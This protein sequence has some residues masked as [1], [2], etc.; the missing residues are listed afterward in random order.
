MRP[1]QRTS[2]GSSIP[3]RP[4]QLEPFPG[5][6]VEDL[7]APAYTRGLTSLPEVQRRQAMHAADRMD[8]DNRTFNQQFW[9][10]M[11]SEAGAVVSGI[12]TERLA[13]WVSRIIGGGGR[14]VDDDSTKSPE[15]QAGP[16]T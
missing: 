16:K 2:P 14:S 3:Y 1:T 10:T 4:P 11:T 7:D 12:G 9:S 15:P 5:S 8:A 6:S 13:R